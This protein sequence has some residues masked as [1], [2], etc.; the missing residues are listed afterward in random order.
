MDSGHE[1]YNSM[2]ESVGGEFDPEH[3]DCSK[4]IFEDPAERLENM[5]EDF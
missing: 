2:F 5:E 3:F 1:E 4:D